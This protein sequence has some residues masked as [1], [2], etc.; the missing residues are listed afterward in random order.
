MGRLNH[1]SRVL[2]QELAEIHPRLIFFQILVSLIPPMAGIRL[3]KELYRLAGISIGKGTVILGKMRLTGEGSIT[4]NLIIG[5]NCVLNELITFN[6]G[7]MVTV[8]DNTS[9]GME[10]LFL[11]VSHQM[12]M[13]EYRGGQT[14]TRPIIVGRGVWM[15][16]RVI[17]LPGVNIG[18]GSVIGAGSVVTQD[19]PANVIAAGVPARVIRNLDEKD[20]NEDP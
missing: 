2:Y 11:T 5:R 4:R 12:G 9:I 19:V 18:P 15:G 16:A 7:E 17:V 13:P 8:E 3:R 10:C 14:L 20:S 6:L 1:I